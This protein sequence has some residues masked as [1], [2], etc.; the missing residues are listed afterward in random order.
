MERMSDA[1]ALPVI[2][3][4]WHGLPVSRI[5]QLSMVSFLR[6]GHVVHLYVYDELPGVPEG[7]E[8]KDAA[9]VLPRSS[10]FFHRRNHSVAHFSDWF[11]YRLLFERGGLWSDTDMVCLKPFDYANPIVFAWQDEQNLNN[12]VLGLPAGDPLAEWLAQSCERPN[13]MLPYDS[14]SQRL[15]KLKRRLKRQG[16]EAVRW[17]GTGPYGLTS[18]ARH[19]GGYL[20][21]A[22]P[23]WHF[24]PIGYEE[25]RRLFESPPPGAPAN[26]NGSRAVH[27]WNQLLDG[28]DKNA[29]FP[30]DSPFERLWAR[31]FEASGAP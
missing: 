12:A 2:Q 23:K 30:Q 29:R 7:V 20:E 17:G 3:M 6:N 28:A 1:P 13:Q 10:L 27:L 5:E 4:F 24:Y 15:A 11:R 21:H 9:E 19:L 26:F 22:L 14:L 18:A 25:S 16:R 31:Y 8:L